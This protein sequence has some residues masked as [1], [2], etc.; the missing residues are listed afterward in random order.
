MA[1]NSTTP[2]FT[3]SITVILLCVR[4][5]CLEYPRVEIRLMGTYKLYCTCGDSGL[6]DAATQKMA[7]GATEEGW[8]TEE[9]R[10]VAEDD[11]EDEENRVCWLPS[12]VVCT[13][14]NLKGAF[15]G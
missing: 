14:L 8:S 15:W 12:S 4:I 3:G 5:E 2:A 10:D 13:P 9:A 1:V 7:L 11:E 6:N